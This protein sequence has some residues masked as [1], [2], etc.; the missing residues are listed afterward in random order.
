MTRTSQT[1]NQEEADPPINFLSSKNVLRIGAWNVRTMYETGR[2]AQVAREM[3]R[4]RL[5]ILGL[6]EVRWVSSGQMTLIS[7]HHLLYS[8]PPEEEG[9][10]RNG[11]GIMLTKEARKSLIEWEPVNERILTA[12]FHSKFQKIS[13]VQ[14]YAPTNVA[15][16]ETKEEFYQQ[17]QATLDKLHRRD[18]VIVMGDMNAKVGNDNGGR[19]HVM[20]K[21]GLGTI[22]ENGELFASFCELND[23]VIAGTVFPHRRINKVT[24][25]SPDMITEN[26]IDHITI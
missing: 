2:S 9:V 21:E 20:G 5:A 12:R 19:E 25:R 1:F 18:I 8:G 6:S 4:Y 7:G 23:L 3:D 22:N 26:Q 11:V 14:C 10:H 24:W 17:L 13:I 15:D 16:D